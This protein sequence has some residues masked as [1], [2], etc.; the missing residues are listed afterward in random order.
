MPT[1]S[2]PDTVHIRDLR[3]TDAEAL[4]AFETENRAWFESHIDPRPASFYSPQG[5]D[6][7]IDRCLSELALGT[8]HP[9]VIE[10]ASGRIVGRANLKQI[11]AQSG[12]AEVGYRIAETA[13]GKGL[14]TQALRHLI[15][16]AHSRWGLTGLVAYVFEENRGSQKVLARC[17]FGRDRLALHGEPG[18]ERRFTLSF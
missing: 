6:E 18:R 2:L 13:A 11:D 15:Q 9:C 3:G 1:P 16:Q 4:L 10:D 5:V 12:T 17:G 7:H 8:W 14:A